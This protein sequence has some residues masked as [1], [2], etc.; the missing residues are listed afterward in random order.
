MELSIVIVNWNSAQL[1]QNCLESVERWVKGISYEGIVVDNNSAPAD[2]L[3]LRQELEPRFHWTKFIYNKVN[4]GFARANNQAVKLAQGKYILILNPDTCF[5]DGYI[6]TL[7]QVLQQENAGMVSCKLLDADNSVQPSCF[8]FPTPLRV[9]ATSLMLHKLMPGRLSRYVSFSKR[10]HGMR[11]KPDWV[12]GA[13]M[14]APRQVL[15]DIGGFDEGIFMYGEDMDLCYRIRR[16]GLEIVYLPDSAVIHYGGCSG[17]QAWSD[18]KREALVCKANFYFYRKFFGQGSLLLV[19]IFYSI[20]AALK[21][22]GYGFTSL[23]PGRLRR[24]IND[25]KTQWVVL[26]TQLDLTRHS[27]L[28]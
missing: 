1:L 4:T 24:G 9:L 7:L 21:L 19:R 22:L 12:L 10:D 23:L 17:K 16:L 13:F 18:A 15:E 25:M 3:L 8:Y 14:L 5:V 6:T 2:T 11:L 26:L 20:G 27:R 28:K